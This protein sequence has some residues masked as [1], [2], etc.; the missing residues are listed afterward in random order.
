MMAI[1]LPYAYLGDGK[2][3]SCR[4]GGA[5]FVEGGLRLIVG[6]PATMKKKTAIAPSTAA[7]S[8]MSSA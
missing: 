2:E 5:K 3:K 8:T 7:A 6:H 1:R 4:A